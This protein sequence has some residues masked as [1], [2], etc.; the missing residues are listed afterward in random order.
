[1]KRHKA[2]KN[3]DEAMLGET[4]ACRDCAEEFCDYW[5]LK[6]HRQDTHPDKRRRCRNDL[7]GDCTFSDDGPYG[8][9]WRHAKAQTTTENTDHDF[10]ETCNLCEQMFK[11]R[12]EMM[13]HKKNRHIE[14]VSLCKEYLK[15]TCDYPA[16]R[17]W[18]RHEKGNHEET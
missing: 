15:G 9:W 10:I 16:Q 12:L 2:A 14:T 17:C 4:K 3:V 13:V 11:N 6:N 7:Q 8:C 1:M 5:N 18:F